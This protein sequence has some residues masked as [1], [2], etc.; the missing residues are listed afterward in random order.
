M[1]TNHSSGA[2]SE[3]RTCCHFG[4]VYLREKA[5]RVCQ[6]SR[7]FVEGVLMLKSLWMSAAVLALAGCSMSNGGYLREPLAKL[8]SGD[9]INEEAEIMQRFGQPAHTTPA[10]IVWR[11]HGSGEQ[12]L[13]VE[14]KGE[15][16]V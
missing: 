13:A 7:R 8:P 16:R 15:M 3:L 6:K 14:G 11:R 5:G 10:I 9:E 2:G 1:Q 4:D 12:L